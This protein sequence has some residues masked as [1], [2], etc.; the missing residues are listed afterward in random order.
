M[1]RDIIHKLVKNA[2][3]NDG[4]TITADPYHLRYEDKSLLADIKAERVLL[5]QRETE[6]IVVEIKSFL[7]AS[8]MKELQTALGQYQMYVAFLES[9]KESTPVYLAT[10]A[11][12]FREEFQS[13][14][15]QMLLKRYG[16]KMIIVDDD[17]EEII[18]WIQ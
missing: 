5:A 6:V 12:V 13:K 3:I 16:V 17:N 9:L 10:T 18:Q 4:W 7:G 2:L 1:A 14:A 11:V 15:V 8:F